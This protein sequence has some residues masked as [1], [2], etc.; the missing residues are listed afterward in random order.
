MESH[1]IT[2]AIYTAK[3]KLLYYNCMTFR[4]Y[5]KQCV[6]CK[7][8]CGKLVKFI[9]SFEIKSGGGL[10]TILTMSVDLTIKFTK[11]GALYSGQ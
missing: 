9:H 6:A 1:N 2:I 5:F 11:F 7:T 8:F 3:T 10:V 4:C